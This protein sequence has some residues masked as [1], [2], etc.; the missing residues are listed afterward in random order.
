MDFWHSLLHRPMIYIK[1]SSSTVC[2]D[3]VCHLVT[4]F[5]IRSLVALTSLKNPTGLVRTPPP[6]F[7]SPR[8]CSV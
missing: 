4:G 1:I 7:L 5:A 2:Q 6:M 8:R 3:L